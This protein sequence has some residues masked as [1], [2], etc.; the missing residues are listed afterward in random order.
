MVGVIL[1]VEVLGIGVKLGVTIVVGVLE[2]A[3]V[4]TGGGMIGVP[5]FY[6]ME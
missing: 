1:G 4:A 2:G 3:P 5:K 6:I